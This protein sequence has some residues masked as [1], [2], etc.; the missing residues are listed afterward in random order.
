MNLEENFPS[1]ESG[2][3]KEKKISNNK[4]DDQNNKEEEKELN[5]ETTYFKMLGDI[6]KKYT[7][8]TTGKLTQEGRDKL[9]DFEKAVNEFK[10]EQKINGRS[11]D[12]DF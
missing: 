11:S 5:Q 1:N 10:K 2:R 9:E 4:I 6:F 7:D 8:K 3:N 12:M